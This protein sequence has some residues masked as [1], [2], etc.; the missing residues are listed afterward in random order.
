MVPPEGHGAPRR[1]RTLRRILR[2]LLRPIAA[3]LFALAPLP[4]LSITI[5]YVSNLINKRSTV[6]AQQIAKLNSTAQEVYSG[7][8][9]VKSYTQERSLGRVFAAQ[10]EDYRIKAMDLAKV[11][12][13]FFG[14]R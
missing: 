4:I 9:V 12:A 2:P 1:P 3:H 6:I 5:Y 8:R 14:G 11:D 10:T 13:A 7:I